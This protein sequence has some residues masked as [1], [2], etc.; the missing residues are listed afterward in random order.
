MALSNDITFNCFDGIFIVEK[1]A[2]TN[3]QFN[4]FRPRI[5]LYITDVHIT[6][7]L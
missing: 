7:N 5:S 1:R 4:H 6:K 2:L 3:N